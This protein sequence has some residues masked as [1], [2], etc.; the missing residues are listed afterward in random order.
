M[1]DDM[2][3]LCDVNITEDVLGQGFPQK[4]SLKLLRGAALDPTSWGSFKDANHHAGSVVV[5][6]A[7]GTSF[8]AAAA[9]AMK[10]QN[11]LAY[12]RLR[13]TKEQLKS[14]SG[15]TGSYGTMVSGISAGP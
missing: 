9:A 6:F 7:P 13:S 3:G 4:Q 14:T 5:S 1:K 10:S 2:V 12:S 15:I 8:P 11:R